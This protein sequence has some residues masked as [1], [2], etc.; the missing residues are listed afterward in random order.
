M[1]TFLTG[2][3]IRST[4][5]LLTLAGTLGSSTSA[6]AAC[7]T[8]FT[9]NTFADTF[10]GVCNTTNCSLRD[11][12]SE[13]NACVGLNEVRLGGGNYGITIPEANPNLDNVDIKTGDFDITD[14]II[15]SG[16]TSP[17]TA[18]S[19]SFRDRIF[20]VWKGTATIQDLQL[21]NGRQLTK[22]RPG[23]AVTIE[24]GAT[25]EL[26]N[27]GVYNNGS[28]TGVGGLDSAIVVFGTLH[29]NGGVFQNNS[30]VSKGCAV[31]IWATTTCFS[32]PK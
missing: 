31:T 30:C 10:D 27:V 16:T 4:I 20:K 15:I 1:K 3:K 13:A 21:M 11:A 14:D 2:K 9:V 29:M 22:K 18:I 19:G 7:Q 8:V 25:A 17:G 28:L 23:T 24:K 6:M 5:F 12:I 32:T 26:K